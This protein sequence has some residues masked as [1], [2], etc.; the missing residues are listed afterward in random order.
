MTDSSNGPSPTTGSGGADPLAALPWATRAAVSIL[1]KIRNS[2]CRSDGTV[3]RWLLNLIDLKSPPTRK[4]VNGISS[5]DFTVDPSRNLWF[6]LFVPTTTAGGGGSLPLIVF[7]HG[8]GFSTMS[9]ASQP[10]DA[11]CR[12][13]AGEVSALVA[14]VQ[15]RLTPEHRF[16]SQ[17]DD[18]FDALRFIA[19]NSNALLPGNADLSRC[20]I[21][22]DSAGGN[23][24]HHVAVRAAQLNP[25][26]IRVRGLIAIQPF[27]GGTERTGSE[28]RNSKCPTLTVSLTDWFWRAFLPEGADRDHWAVN[29]S[30]PNAV[31]ISKLADFPATI[32]FAG[33]MDPLHDWQVK[34]YEWLRKSGK[35]AELV[36][37]PDM[38][39]AFYAFPEIPESSQLISKVKEFVARS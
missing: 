25:D 19:E 32:V 12:R 39:H 1:I 13:L 16:P 15:Y 27:F 24:A 11:Y 17:Y 28:I 10:Y 35:E 4:P 30:G 31:D 29:V 20:F 6:R 5:S 9:P 33:R 21:A 2:A 37:Y 7:F 3:N 34:Y 8:G 38:V 14:S 22:G 23:L 36:E 26:R 18:G